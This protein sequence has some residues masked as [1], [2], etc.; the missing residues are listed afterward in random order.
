MKAPLF[1]P[2]F[3]GPEDH[4][5][6]ALLIDELTRHA[7]EPLRAWQARAREPLRV[8][9]PEG[10]R[11]AASEVLTKLCRVPSLPR[12]PAPSALRERLFKCA[13]S[14][15]RAHPAGAL[16]RDAL[17]AAAAQELALS[18]EELE[19]RLFADLAS[20][21]RLILPDQLPGPHELALRTNHALAQGYL[22]AATKIELAVDG[23]TRGVLRQILLR[24]LLC[25]V[26][27]DGARVHLEISGPLALFRRTTL[28][29]RALAS[30]LPSLRG[31]AHFEIRAHVERS[32]QALRVQL[33]SGDPLFPPGIAAPRYDSRLEERFARDFLRAAPDWEL[34]REPEPIRLADAWL[35]PDFA[36]VHRLSRRRVLLEIVGFWTPE[37]LRAKFERLR[38]AARADLLIC[39]DASRA[40]AAELF[41]DHGRILL[42]RGQVDVAAVR[43]ALD[44]DPAASPPLHS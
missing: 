44:A 32:G 27:V 26:R 11:R 40:C 8:P 15:R 39:V 23:A 18:V 14:E 9:S 28:Y 25:T 12:D 1:Q 4:P 29:G 21:R 3:L 10:K 13:V 5:W 33:R 6:L 20:E 30:V 16:A 19:R 42:Y 24:R 7:G 35:F 41:P 34:V 2:R 31:V 22:R 36:L 43:R 17:V 38:E 37:Y